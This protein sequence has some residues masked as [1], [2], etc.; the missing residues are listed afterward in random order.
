VG[1]R[2]LQLTVKGKGCRVQEGRIV[3]MTFGRELEAWNLWI[4]ES[5]SIHDQCKR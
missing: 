1:I 2:R 5:N 4:F 3:S